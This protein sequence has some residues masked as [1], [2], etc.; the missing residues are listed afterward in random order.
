MAR[1]RSAAAGNYRMEHMRYGRNNKNPAST[2]AKTGF[3]LT[4]AKK[5]ADP[6]FDN[7]LNTRR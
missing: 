2:F 7:E 5:M 3:T 6:Q 1:L 4:P